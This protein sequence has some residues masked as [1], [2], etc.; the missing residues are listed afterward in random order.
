M[1]RPVIWIAGGTDK[2]NDYSE[3]FPL[4]SKKVKALICMGVDNSKLLQAFSDKVPFAT[5][6]SS[7][8]DALYEA[9]QNAEPG[10]VVL[11]SPACASFDLFKNYEHRGELFK[12]G[13]LQ[14]KN[15]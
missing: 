1:T 8:D 15:S 12:N 5:S 3:L 14:M 11:L 4:V 6:T 13:V 9:S 2:G 10:D 7:L